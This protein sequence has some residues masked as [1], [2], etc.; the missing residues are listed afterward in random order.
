MGLVSAVFDGG[1]GGRLVACV[2]VKVDRRAVDLLS[3]FTPFNDND[4]DLY[5]SVGWR[6]DAL[7][8]AGAALQQ[9]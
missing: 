9:R 5:G 2:P 1:P 4:T 3:L 8:S 6:P 7:H